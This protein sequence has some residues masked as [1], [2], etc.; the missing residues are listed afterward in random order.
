MMG[1]QG[2]GKNSRLTMAERNGRAQ[3]MFGY[4]R[5]STPGSS[6]LGLAERV[7]HTTVRDIRKSHGHAV[8]GLLL[9]ILQSILFIAVFFLLVALLR[10]RTFA[11][12]GD[13]L[14]FIIS[15]VFVFMVHV[16]AIGAVAGA[17]G[18]TS[19]MMKHAP[20]N[21]AIA[22]MSAALAS[23]Y[24]QILSMMVILFVVHTFWA[25]LDIADPV[26]AMAMIL[27]GWIS[28]VGI[29]M[30]LLAA[31]PWNPTAVNLIAT[32]IMRVNMV[33][34]GK[35]IV[36]NQLAYTGLMLFGWN[37]VYHIIDHSRGYVFQNYSPHFTVL[38]Y[39]IIF[40]MVAIVLGMM[41]EFFTR[42]SASVSW[43]AG[44]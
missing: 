15:G 43:M 18:P 13:P 12:R 39:P 5:Y 38:S 35:M 42:K 10:S 14:M 6:A 19:G 2:N 29:G 11:L 40:S 7:F 41:G 4:R 21:T 1:R 20:M 34:S 32:I 30:V 25:P 24:I 8:I 16:K 37:P 33:A 23:L 27:L 26:G 9:N 3:G 17:E 22:I 31:K 28:G 44:K 36:A